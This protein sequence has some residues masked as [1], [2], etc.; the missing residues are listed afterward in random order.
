MKGSRRLRQAGLLPCSPRHVYA[1]ALGS[2]RRFSR[3]LGP[4]ALVRAGA[5]ALDAAPLR[6][7]GFS[8]V[9][10]T[11]PMGPARRRY[12]NA[13]AIVATALPP[14]ALIRH[15]H[16]LEDRFG[17]RRAR[18]WGDRTLDLDIILWSGGAHRSA[19]LVIP[20]PGFRLRAFVL[21]PLAALTPRWRDPLTGRT[22]RQLLARLNRPKPVD[23]AP[24]AL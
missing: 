1:V 7:L 19:G 14:P 21:A 20:H 8:G 17:R 6:L 24:N 10:D 12:A 18:R 22:V 3:G 15:L 16:A 13:A 23:H 2:N 5:R 4:R 9:I 11:A